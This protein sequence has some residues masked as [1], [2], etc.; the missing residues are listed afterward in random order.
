MMINLLY[1]VLRNLVFNT[2]RK[3]KYGHRYRFDK[4]ERF[5][6]SVN[7]NLY[8][9]GECQ[10]GRNIELAK[11][12]DIQVHGN[13][14]L[15]IGAGTYMNRFCM[16]SCHGRVSIGEG[17]MFGP[18]VKIFD[19]NH[20]FNSG[21][22]VLSDL[23]IGEISVGDHCWIASNVILLKGARIGNNC[24]IGAGC[25]INKAIP[26][27]SIVKQKSQYIIENITDK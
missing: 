22:G 6:H 19:N 3:V 23:S 26:D 17:C 4:I 9:K 24:V 10:L 27:N 2:I 12:V 5:A 20:K 25:I 14:C 21:E 1:T 16:I 18:S 7:I 8:V 11:D 13:G 15:S